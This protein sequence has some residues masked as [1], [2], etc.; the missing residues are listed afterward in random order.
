MLPACFRFFR[1]FSDVFKDTVRNPQNSFKFFSSTQIIS[2]PYI[3]FQIPADSSKFFQV[4]PFF[5]LDF[6]GSKFF[7]MRSNCHKFP[8]IP[9]N[10][11]RISQFL[12]DSF[13][14]FQ[15]FLNSFGM[16]QVLSNSFRFPQIPPDSFIFFLILSFRFFRFFYSFGLFT[17]FFDVSDPLEILQN[18][19]KFF[20]VF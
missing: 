17:M 8:Q 1:I 13:R 16:S 20:L 2:D 19:S 3:S 5:F 14:F 12:S 4:L 11:F 10:S 6:L 15:I 7:K 9:S 18:S